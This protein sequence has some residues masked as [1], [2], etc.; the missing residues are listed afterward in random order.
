MREQPDIDT[1]T[2]RTAQCSVEAGPCL[3]RWEFAAQR[4]ARAWRGCAHVC[5][6][7]FVARIGALGSQCTVFHDASQTGR[8]DSQRPDA[9]HGVALKSPSRLHSNMAD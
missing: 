5:L 3:Q 6:K 8:T 7:I 1:H 9:V 4:F 2:H